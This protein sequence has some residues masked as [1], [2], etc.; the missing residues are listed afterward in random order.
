M[1][2]NEM[3]RIYLFSEYTYTYPGGLVW[4]KGWVSL[5]LRWEDP[6]KQVG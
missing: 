3:L 2:V 5:G 1:F 6:P 4:V